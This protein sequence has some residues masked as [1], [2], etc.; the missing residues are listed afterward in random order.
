MGIF[1][2]IEKII[3]PIMGI[4]FINRS[5]KKLL[6]VGF[7][8]HPKL[9]G[10]YEGVMFNQPK[11]EEILRTNALKYSNIQFELGSYVSSLE[12]LDDINNFEVINNTTNEKSNFSSTYL[13]GSDGA[14]S[15][16]RKSLD[17]KMHDYNCDQDW[18]VVDY[19]VDDKFEI[20]D[21]SRYQICD[22][23][24]PTTLLPITDLS[25]IHI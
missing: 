8:D 25:L 11:F 9:N 13:I 16:V 22:Y 2:Q 5:G 3:D 15:F 20:L 19:F 21:R 18:V 17:I 7:E 6:S 4:N 24:R 23:K 12:A 1:D 10:Y 14:D